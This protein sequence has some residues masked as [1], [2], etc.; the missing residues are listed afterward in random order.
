ME[1]EQ[2]LAHW[3][4]EGAL[5]EAPD[6]GLINRTWLAGTPP[7]AVLQW[8]SPIFDPVIHLN[9]A[10]VTARLA[11]A[12]L[13]T[14]R[15]LPTRGGE[16][17]QA[18]GDAV[19]R[20]MTFIPGRTLH[21]LASPAQAAAAGQLVGRF[22]AALADW[23]F[24]FH[25]SGR[26]LH[27]TK[28]RMEALGATLEKADR[29]PLSSE[30]RRVGE[31]ILEAWASW[32]GEL[33]QPQ[34]PCHGDL[35]VSN[36]RFDEGGTEAVCLLDLDTLAPQALAAEMGDAWRSWCNPADEGDVDACR[37]DMTL[38]TASAQ[39][40]GAAAPPLAPGERES[41]VPGIERICLELASRFCTD[42][43]ENTYFR[44]DRDRFPQPGAHN[45]LR[46]RGQLNLARSAR[47]QRAACEAVLR[48][49]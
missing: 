17:W 13:T 24:R 5:R 19:W 49:P 44:E 37:L 34:R 39:A 12:G 32:D 46:A 26:P 14:P 25:D 27:D 48:Q 43:V 1:A 20:L 4:E 38:F 41:L 33:A 2:A 7:R 40:W 9:I 22:H 18:D 42:A 15:L 11:A 31:A 35:K 16:L 28:G 47:A 30:A 36:L 21:H 45:L 6:A 10:A 23:D 8:V 3:E 29:H